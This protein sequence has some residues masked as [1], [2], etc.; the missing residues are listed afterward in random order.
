[1]KVAETPNIL[2]D[3][4][5][6]QLL[7]AFVERF[8]VKIVDDETDHETDK[9]PFT[10]STAQVVTS[11]KPISSALITQE[12]EYVQ[13]IPGRFSPSDVSK[14]IL[15]IVYEE[16]AVWKNFKMVRFHSSTLRYE[17][18]VHNTLYGTENIYGLSN[19]HDAVFFKH[20]NKEY[21][22][23]VEAVFGFWQLRAG[24]VYL[25]SL[26]LLRLL[27]DVHTEDGNHNVTSVYG[28]RQLKYYMSPSN[29]VR[30]AIVQDVSLL[31]SV[32]LVIDL[33]WM[34]QTYGPLKSFEVLMEDI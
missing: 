33:S 32:L 15:A 4:I 8:D 14:S 9:Q 23:F 2:V 19:L 16:L 1:M 34:R 10:L 26:F 5:S 25:K 22:G 7:F 31:R 11:T 24:T 20:I 6:C 12:I 30:T 17:D 13:I 18:I 28:Q 21:I 29:F 27:S 3:T